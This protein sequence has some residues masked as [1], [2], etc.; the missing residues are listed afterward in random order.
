MKTMGE[1]AHDA[2]ASAFGSQTASSY[3]GW[4]R[5]ANGGWAPGAVSV[6]GGPL[7]NGV[8]AL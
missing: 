4:L 3:E 1:I 2:G 5:V 8:D 6:G 7:T